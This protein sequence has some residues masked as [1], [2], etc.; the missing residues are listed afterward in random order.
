MS[1]TSPPVTSKIQLIISRHSS[2]ARLREN[3]ASGEKYDKNKSI[4][5]VYIYIYIYLNLGSLHELN[6]TIKRL[7]TRRYN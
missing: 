7:P 5:Y 3:R 2:G 6:E 1:L 4:M